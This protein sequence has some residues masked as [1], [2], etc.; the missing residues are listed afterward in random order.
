MRSVFSFSVIAAAMK[1]SQA[2]SRGRPV[3][4][5]MADV[6]AGVVRH[7]GSLALEALGIKGRLKVHQYW[8]SCE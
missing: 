4:D 7:F 6:V 1:L 2:Q 3:T 8:L 5:C